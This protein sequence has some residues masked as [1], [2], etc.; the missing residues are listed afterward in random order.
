MAVK[1]C[2]L[3]QRNVTP[4]RK[5]GV[6]TLIGVFFTGFI[7]VLFIPFYKKDVLYAWATN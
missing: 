2:T 1:Y 7:W 3:C 5:I 4:K 6:G